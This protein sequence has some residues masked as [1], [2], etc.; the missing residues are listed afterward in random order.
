MILAHQKSAGQC[1][2]WEQIVLLPGSAAPAQGTSLNELVESV[3][4]RQLSHL[5]SGSCQRIRS[6]KMMSGVLHPVLGH[7]AGRDQN[8]EQ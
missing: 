4:F 3:L 5:S 7:T 8:Q 1:V 6:T 2:P